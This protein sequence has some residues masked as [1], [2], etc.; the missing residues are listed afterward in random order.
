V[1]GI[2]I[3]RAGIQ[4]TIQDHG[5]IG[6]RGLGV[7]VCG[8]LDRL[9]HDLANALVGNLPEAATLE[10]T[11]VGDELLFFEAAVI[12]LTGAKV[13]ATVHTEAGEL[14]TLEMNGPCRVP[15]GAVLRTGAIKE[16]CRAYLAVSGGIDAPIVLGSRSTD[17]RSGFGGM[18]GQTLKQAMELSVGNAVHPEFRSTIC[19][20]CDN[21]YQSRWF[22][23]PASLRHDTPAVVR[24]IAG[25]CFEFMTA[26]SQKAFL[27]ESFT[28]SPRSNRMG[29]RLDGP[30][31][32]LTRNETLV[33]EG[34][35]IGT[36]QLPPDGNPILLMHDCAPT[37]GYPRIAHVIRADLPIAAQVRPGQ[38]LLF[39]MSDLSGA[40]QACRE[41]QIAL[42]RTRQMI[43]LKLVSEFF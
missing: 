25:K 30:E 43:R 31:L 14:R 1:A 16:H 29:Y 21:V 5:R 7:S 34:V 37:G 26:D 8:A 39:R 4:T 17:L 28:V 33:S 24:V 38:P 6:Y 20:K 10:M 22:S 13:S 32:K 9:S 18:C 23:R 12:A 27:G 3:L 36:I 19:E 11:L 41:Q 42:S 2:H 15:A 35:A 40:V